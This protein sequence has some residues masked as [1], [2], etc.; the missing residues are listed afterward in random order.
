MRERGYELEKREGE[1][2]CFRLSS[3]IG[4]VRRMWEDRITVTPSIEGYSLEG[5]N[6]D[7]VRLINAL[8]MKFNPSDNQ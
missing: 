8:E 6:K 5:P 3:T 4:K 1:S 2:L 7:V